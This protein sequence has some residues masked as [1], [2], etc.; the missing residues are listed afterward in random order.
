MV[1]RILRIALPVIILALGV[2]GAISLVKSKPVPE[3]DQPLVKPVPLVEI[4]RATPESGSL[5][6]RSQGTVL[7]RTETILSA[8]LRAQ[9]IE[10][11]PDFEVGGFKRGESL[12]RLD[13]R[14]FER[15]VHE[16]EAQVARARLVLTR[17]EA[18][19]R[20]AAEE[21]RR[22]GE[23]TTP[24]SLVLRRPQLA[25]ARASLAAAEAELERVRLDLERSTVSAPFTGRIRSKQVDV[26]QLVSP[27][28]ELATIYSIESFEVRLPVSSPNLAFLEMPWTRREDSAAT[29]GAG[30][31]VW[32]LANLAGQ[33]RT[34]RGRIVRSEGEIAERSR[35]I[36]LVARVEDPYGGGSQGEI[37]LQVGLFVEAAIRGRQFEEA[38][39]VPRAAIREGDRALVVDDE[40]R[41]RFREVDVLRFQEDIAVIQGGDLEVGERICI[42]PLAVVAEGM[43]VETTEVPNPAVLPQPP[44]EEMSLSAVVG[45]SNDPI[46]P[47]ARLM[48][49][50]TPDLGY[51]EPRSRVVEIDAAEIVGEGAG[52]RIS[53][54]GAS[55][56]WATFHLSAPNRF[57]VDLQKAIV[58]DGTRN[59][60]IEDGPVL[61]VRWAQFAGEPEPV[62]RIVFDLRGGVSSPR[63]LTQQGKGLVVVFQ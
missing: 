7:P 50:E 63:I 19:A 2:G 48:V 11:S 5:L 41:L 55:P 30:P 1:R 53:T 45:V 59:L 28:Q 18:E 35:M 54:V 17:E 37:P 15:A 42:S 62:V 49:G 22:L 24:E 61:G 58:D 57:I 43:R 13:R 23:V 14:D 32:L 40:M 4:I 25:E 39:V 16:A 60:R 29:P 46:L 47:K 51:L 34:W 36:H 9:I 56:E 27:G 26:G 20:L 31:E 8:Q 10:T 12:I 44:V 6:V 52:F 21:W 3:A 33:E 38:F